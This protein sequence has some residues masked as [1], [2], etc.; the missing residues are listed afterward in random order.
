MT[1][2]QHDEFIEYIIASA[3]VLYVSQVSVMDPYRQNPP[4]PLV[5]PITLI[6]T[7]YRLLSHQ[8]KTFSSVFN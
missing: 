1:I 5:L 7:F 3:Y 4:S 2:Y 6:L 8:L